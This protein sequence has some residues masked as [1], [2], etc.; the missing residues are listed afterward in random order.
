MMLFFSESLAKI[1]SIG[2]V[3]KPLPEVCPEGPTNLGLSGSES[4]PECGFSCGCGKCDLATY[5]EKGC[6]SSLEDSEF[7]YLFPKKLSMPEFRMFKWNL[8]KASRK[9]V[10]KFASLERN[11]ISMLKEKEVPLDEVKNYVLTLG[12]M[13]N[14]SVYRDKPLLLQ[15]RTRIETVLDFGSLFLVLKGYYS[16]FSFSIIEDLREDFLCSAET[17]NDKVMNEYK[18]DFVAYCRRRIFE[19]PKSML[20]NPHS[21]GFVPLSLKV[22][23]NFNMYSLNCVKE[24]EASICETLRLSKHTLQLCD[25]TDGCVTVVFKIPSWLGD[26]ITITSEQQQKLVHIGV[27]KLQIATHTL[28]EVEVS[29]KY[30]KYVSSLNADE[31][32][33]ISCKST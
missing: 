17:G 23:E 6:P 28:Y 24:F 8:Q 5:L 21:E 15:E 11:T 1:F 25:V 7:P 32:N 9:I 12:V 3:A 2:T 30:R 14:E 31:F 26:T 29:V 10:R 16:W 13:H 33:G 19:C 20:S 18:S 4:D 22:D 27:I